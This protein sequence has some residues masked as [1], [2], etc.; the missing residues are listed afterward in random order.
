[1]PRHCYINRV[2]RRHLVL[3]LSCFHTYFQTY[4]SAHMPHPIDP[5]HLSA[6]FMTNTSSIVFVSIICVTECMLL[7][8]LT[9]LRA[10]AI[11]DTYWRHTLEKKRRLATMSRTAKPQQEMEEVIDHSRWSAHRSSSG[12][13]D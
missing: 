10:H 9:T 2:I 7:P 11:V 13:R 12:L 6:R 4:E 1:M 8:S 3:A 5:M